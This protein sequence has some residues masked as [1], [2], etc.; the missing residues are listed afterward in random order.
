MYRGSTGEYCYEITCHEY[1]I[2]YHEPPTD[3]KRAAQGTLNVKYEIE[4]KEGIKE[5]IKQISLVEYQ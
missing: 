1:E 5:K 2:S 4:T 3:S